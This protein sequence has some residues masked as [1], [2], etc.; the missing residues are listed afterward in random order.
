MQRK[1]KCLHTMQVS[2]VNKKP[3]FYTSRESSYINAMT[4]LATKKKTS[5]TFRESRLWVEVVELKRYYKYTVLYWIRYL[6]YQNYLLTERVN[7]YISK[8]VIFFI[9]INFSN[10]Y[11]FRVHNIIR[12]TSLRPMIRVG[13]K[14]LKLLKVC[15]VFKISKTKPI[16]FGKV[17]LLYINTALLK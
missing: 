16:I 15:S 12:L 1:K 4:F 5:F 11:F 14:N 13:G 9:C 6:S 3:A 2:R 10:I 7:L 8:K 17:P